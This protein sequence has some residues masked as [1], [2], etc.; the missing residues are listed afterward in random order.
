MIFLKNYKHFH[1]GTYIIKKTYFPHRNYLEN[2]MIADLHLE[3]T[4]NLILEK[5]PE[6]Y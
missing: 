4:I 1:V 5:L 6:L 3:Y 2:D